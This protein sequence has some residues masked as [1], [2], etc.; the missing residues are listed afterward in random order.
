MDLDE[1]EKERGGEVAWEAAQEPISNMLAIL[2]RNEG[3]FFL[4]GTSMYSS[5][6]IY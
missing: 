2:K 1:F 5:F 3:P 4:G 6:V